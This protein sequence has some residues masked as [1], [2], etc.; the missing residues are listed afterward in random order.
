MPAFLRAAE[1]EQQSLLVAEWMSTTSDRGWV[2]AALEVMRKVFRCE[3]GPFIKLMLAV[4][5]PLDAVPD[6]T[7]VIFHLQDLGTIETTLKDNGF[8]GPDDWINAMRT[9]FRNSIVYNKEDGGIG[10]DIIQAAEA[11]S[12][13]FEKEMLRL[14]GV[15]VI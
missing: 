11:A 4:P 15:T 6:Y 13:V 10:S 2:K 12:T 9:V 7:R 8:A 1:I 5:V 14:K 3:Q